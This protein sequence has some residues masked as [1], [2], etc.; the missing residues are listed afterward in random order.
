MSKLTHFTKLGMLLGIL[1]CNASFAQRVDPNYKKMLEQYY[2]DFSTISGD[3]AQKLIGIENVYFLD[4]REEKEFLVS[5][6]PNA[7]WVGYDHLNWSAIKK[8]P[9]DSHV[10]VYCSVGARSQNI[11][12]KLVQMGF[13]HVDN[14]YGGLF[15]WANQRR[16][17]H[18]HKGK[19]TTKIHGYDPNWGKWVTAGEVVYF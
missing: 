9:R 18:D 1:F 13:T 17:L 4:T 10:I 3:K 19:K 8:L 14:L 2:S 6:I 16:I 7:I 15:L 12:E 11:G 5:H